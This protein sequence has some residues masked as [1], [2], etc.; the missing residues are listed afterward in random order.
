MIFCAKSGLLRPEYKSGRTAQS[1]PTAKPYTETAL[2]MKNLFLFAIGMALLFT[3]AF[4]RNTPLP[5][6][7][8]MVS[9]K[10]PIPSAP[11]LPVQMDK[12]DSIAGFK[13]CEKA[14]WSQLTTFSEEYVYQRYTVK[15]TR[16]PDKPGEQI[17]VKRDSGRADFVIPMPED[18]YFRGVS[19]NKLFVDAKNEAG[20]RELLVFEL[21]RMLQFFNIR[22]CGD[23]EIISHEKIYFLIPV[24][25]AEVTRIPDCP[26]KEEWTKNGLKVGYGQRA[27]FK[28]MKRSLTRK[29]EWACVP[30]Q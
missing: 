8:T 28:F 7:Q 17:T 6:G 11:D 29:S 3:L 27:I 2:F 30:L 18:G 14:S 12:R 20:G 22:Y 15:I 1:R 26:Q 4:C 10:T 9:D 23:P 16:N 19:R 21:D 25:E 5:E 13:G 24:D